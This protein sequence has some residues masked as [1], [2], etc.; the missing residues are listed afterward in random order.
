MLQQFVFHCSYWNAWL[1]NMF[2]LGSVPS[3]TIGSIR[4]LWETQNP[5]TLFPQHLVQ[6]ADDKT[7]PLL[8]NYSSRRDGSDVR[9]SDALSKDLGS[10]PST[11]VAAHNCLTPAPCDPICNPLL[12]SMGT[13]HAHDTKTHLQVTFWCTENKIICFKKWTPQLIFSYGTS[14][15]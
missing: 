8:I 7:T 12:A 3:C 13:G 15:V 14:K 6:L 1:S 5:W 4:E 10:I 11:H 9:T 2:T